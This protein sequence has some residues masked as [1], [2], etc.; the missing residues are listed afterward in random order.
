MTWLITPTV[1]PLAVFAAGPG[2]VT[3]V[4]RTVNGI[5]A[6]VSLVPSSGIFTS[7][8]S[9][10]IDISSEGSLVRCYDGT[11]AEVGNETISV[12]SR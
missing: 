1:G 12:A 11:L 6:T 5:T 7:T 3:S 8:L 4:T 10:V 9:M 2:P